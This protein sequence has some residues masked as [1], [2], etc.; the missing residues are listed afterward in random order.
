MLD[1]ALDGGRRRHVP[2]RAYQL[3]NL[4]PQFQRPAGRVRFPERH[5]SG[6]TRSGGDQHAIV[7]DLFDPP[8]RR[9]EQERLADPAFEDHLLVELADTGLRPALT[10]KEHAVQ[11]AVRN[12]SAVDDRDTFGALAGGQPVLDS[13]PGQPR[14]QIRE[15]VRWVASRKHVEHAFVDGSA[16][17]GKRRGT[18]DRVEQPIDIPFVG[19]HHRDDLLGQHVERISRI[20][21]RLDAGFVHGPRHGRACDEIATKLRDDYAAACSTDCVTSAADAL[22]A[23]GNRRWRLDLYDQVDCAHINAQFK[24]RGR[25]ETPDG[26]GL[27]PILDL[28]ALRARERSVMG[29]DERLARE[30][31]QRGRQP[32]SG[33][34]VVDEDERGAMCLDELKEPR[35]NG[36]PDR[37]SH[38]TPRRRPTLNVDRLAYLRHV[39]DRHF[40]SQ[41]EI[42]LLGRVDD[43]DGPVA[44]R[45][46][47]RAE[48]VMNGFVGVRD[49]CPASGCSAQS[50]CINQCAWG[51]TPTRSRS[52]APRGG[53]SLRPLAR[54]A[55]AFPLSSKESCNLV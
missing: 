8:A 47:F 41:I 32:L 39:L 52:G 12:G 7:R 14:P 21:A 34:A 5:L 9:A 22:H 35:M 46:G 38:R 2:K 29:P 1:Q 23:A 44:G 45:H 33:A 49:R 20:A 27:Q 55:G 48:F 6:Y 42:L 3:A 37:R 36:R 10:D 50:V 53:A 40:D 30:L 25:D 13:I 24:G 51:P 16:Q 18:S 17:I 54:A 11:P 15:V 43:R 4:A 26:A 31:V 19:R 28:D